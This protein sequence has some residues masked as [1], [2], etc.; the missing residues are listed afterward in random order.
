M[1]D[2]VVCKIKEQDLGAKIRRLKRSGVTGEILDRVIADREKIKAE[3]KRIEAGSNFEQIRKN[4]IRIDPV[5]KLY[6]SGE[7]D[8]EQFTAAEEIRDMW[9][10]ISRGRNL[11]AGNMEPTIKANGPYKGPIEKLPYSLDP[12]FRK[13]WIPW[14]NEMSKIGVSVGSKHRLK[15]V[16][17]L[18]VLIDIAAERQTFSEVVAKIGIRKTSGLDLLKKIFL[19]GLNAWPHGR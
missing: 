18:D 13:K 8:Q 9:E 12:V 3:R 17:G 6:R 1:S 16:R 5:L 2:P 7:I 14:A 4:R 19:D 11:Q 10:A 15:V